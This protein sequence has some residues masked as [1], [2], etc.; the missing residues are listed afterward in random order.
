VTGPAALATLWD[1]TAGT[2]QEV[3]GFSAV[4]SM[5]FILVTRNP[6]VRT[7]RDFTD[8]DRIALPGVKVAI[9]ALMLQIAVAQIWGLDQY[10]R[11]DHLTVSLPHPDAVAAVLSPNNEINSHYSVAP[12]QYFELAQPGIH[13]VI[14]SYDTFGGKHTNGV[15]I[16]SKAFRDGNPKPYAAV[17]AALE[18]ANVFIRAHPREAAQIY[19][20]LANDKRSALDDIASIIANPDNDWT[21]T[22]VNVMKMAEFM[23]KVGRIKRVPASWKDMFFPEVHGLAGS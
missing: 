10:D 8:K 6:A 7:L 22:P 13:Q 14:K 21:T 15:M 18:E 16:V 2:A 4:Q 11:L 23:H 5:P 17:L 3:R 12:F 19:L 9:Q 20:T 1:K